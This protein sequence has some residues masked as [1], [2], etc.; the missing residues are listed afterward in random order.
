MC[1]V[2]AAYV[3]FLPTADCVCAAYVLRMCCVCD[4]LTYSRLHMCC[5][6][7]V[8]VTFLPTAAAYVLRMCCVCDLPTADCVCAAYV[9]RM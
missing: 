2:C 9:L 1:C 4:L 5:V 8:Y 3:T 6:C 7:A